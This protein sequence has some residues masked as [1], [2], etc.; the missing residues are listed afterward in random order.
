MQILLSHKAVAV[1]RSCWTR[2]KREWGGVCLPHSA[3]GGSQFW[4]SGRSSLSP[5]SS[6]TTSEAD[7]CSVPSFSDFFLLAEDW[8]SRGCFRAQMITSFVRPGSWFL[9]QYNFLSKQVSVWSIC[10]WW[11]SLWRSRAEGL[12]YS[13][14]LK[15][16]IVFYLC[17]AVFCLSLCLPV[18]ICL[19]D[20]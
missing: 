3:S 6:L 2:G 17:T 18:F 9:W 19:G 14:F 16:K 15:L 12:M 5:W 11:I 4:L 10:F 8:G 1:I 7:F 20:H 13:R